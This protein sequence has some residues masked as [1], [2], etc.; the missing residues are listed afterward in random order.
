MGVRDLVLLG[1]ILLMNSQD[2]QYLGS[3]LSL[4]TWF[5]M[6]LMMRELGQAVRD[7]LDELAC[8]CVPV[9]RFDS[10]ENLS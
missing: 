2:L 9:D 4:T 7:A 3:F 8:P 1:Y 6:C 5:V 10:P